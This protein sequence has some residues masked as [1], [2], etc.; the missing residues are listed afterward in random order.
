ELSFRDE[1]YMPFEGAGAVSRWVL[2]LPKTFKQFDYHTI[3]DVIVSISYTA[4]QDGALRT[5]VEADN[6]ALEGAIRKVL[7]ERPLARVFSL[8]QDFSS[9]FAR[10]LH[11][12]AGTAVPIEIGAG[13]FPI[14]IGAR[15]IVVTRAQMLLRT[16]EGAAPGGFQ[17]SVDT[18]AVSGFAADPT[19]GGL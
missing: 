2:A 13:H 4:E 18:A 15:P 17:L 16:A 5:R 9:A 6:A 12:P 19:L 10:L 3:N 7:A 11:S 1:R 14:F 8:R